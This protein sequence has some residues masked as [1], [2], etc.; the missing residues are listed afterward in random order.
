MNV[1][2]NAL[3]RLIVLACAGICILTTAGVFP[4]SA[5]DTA[6]KKESAS[7]KTQTKPQK[8][9][10]QIIFEEQ[11]I[12]GKIRRPQMVLI[13]ADERPSFPSMVLTN[14]GRNASIAEF[15]DPSVIEKTPNLGA[16]QFEGN[17]ISNLVK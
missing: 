12:E 4:V 11:K 13:K 8:S 14:L 5:A 6:E 17:R 9:V 1:F 3:P 10:Q 2:M 7:D 15:V 16:F